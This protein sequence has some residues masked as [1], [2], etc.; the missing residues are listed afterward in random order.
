[1]HLKVNEMELKLLTLRRYKLTENIVWIGG[2]SMALILGQIASEE[3]L[4]VYGVVLF[5]SLVVST[6]FSMSRKCPRCTNYFHGSNPIWGN[7]L[8]RSCV[9][10]GLHISGKNA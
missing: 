9:H 7:T 1:M 3:T 10:C 8:R 2:I 5:I 6:L 4:K